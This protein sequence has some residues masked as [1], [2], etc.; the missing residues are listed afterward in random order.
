MDTI[1]TAFVDRP[2]NIVVVGAGISGIQFIKDATTR[3]KNVNV[4]VYE[5]NSDIGGTWFENRYPGCACDVPSHAY[6]YSW[7]QNPSWSRLY[8]EAP[9]ILKYLQDTVDK[10]DLRKYIQCNY[11]CTAAKWNE[12]TSQW[13]VDF[14]RTDQPSL[15]FTVTCDVFVYAVGRLNNWKLPDI[16]GLKDFRGEVVHTANWPSNIDLSGKDVAVIGNGSSA[17]QCVAKLHREVKS[18]DNFVRSPTWIV[19]H[20]FSPN[21]ESQVVYSQEAI[22][23]YKRDPKA[24]YD[25]R[26]KI[27]KQLARGF[28][29]LWAGTAASKRFTD[30][31]RQHMAKHIKDKSYLEALTPDYSAGCRRFTP[32]DNYL[33]ALNQDNV[34]LISSPIARA[35]KTSL[36]T[37]NGEKRSYDVIVCATGFDPYSPRFPVVGREGSDLSKLWSTEG[38]YES[39]MA[40]TVAGFPNFFV[41]GSAYPGIER[42]SDYMMRVIKR[43]QVDNVKSVCVRNAA[44]AEFSEWVQQRMSEMVWSDN[45]SSWYKTKSGKIIVPWPGTTLHYYAAT[46][47]VRWEDY[48]IE[49]SSPGEKY[50][51]FGNGITPE[52]FTPTSIPWLA[53]GKHEISVTPEISVKQQISKQPE[54]SVTEI[55]V[56]DISVTDISVKPT[57]SRES[58]RNWRN[59]V[60]VANNATTSTKL[61]E[62]TIN[63]Q[64][65]QFNVGLR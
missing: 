15:K 18:V 49:H 59:M 23:T 17:L 21:G 20:V 24:Y 22:E 14:E 52:G 54:I 53:E 27:E 63:S 36:Q 8:A 44:Q 43:L 39:Y 3:L 57:R 34:R 50:A 32:S 62:L 58:R 1:P 13:A 6:S 47:F 38:D 12:S 16:P 5:K 45:C 51:S 19:P 64:F 29:G 9:E 35:N 28:A 30:A 40:V 42:G 41:S 31:A 11:K 60:R 46:E 48:E 25:F 65:N 61:I 33:K 10:H 56:T 37:Q 2:L 7:N 26:L 55:S 4:T